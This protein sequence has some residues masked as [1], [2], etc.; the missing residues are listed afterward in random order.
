L[1]NLFFGKFF[2]I[3][4]KN[5]GRM[6]LNTIDSIPRESRPFNFI[7]EGNARK[8]I[9]ILKCKFAERQEDRTR[10]KATR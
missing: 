2:L 8:F 7:S 3:N 5:R 6:M 9:A 4:N 1:K 10:A